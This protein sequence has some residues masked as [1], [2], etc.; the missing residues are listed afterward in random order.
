MQHSGAVVHVW[1]PISYGATSVC[2]RGWS[3]G[4]FAARPDRDLRIVTMTLGRRFSQVSIDAKYDDC[5]HGTI[6]P[7]TIREQ[8]SL[9]SDT[10]GLPIH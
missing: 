6:D 2:R 1:G 7:A 8:A 9:Q 5:L 10:E 3:E 4:T